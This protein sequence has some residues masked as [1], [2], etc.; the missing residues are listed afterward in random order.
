MQNNAQLNTKLP[1]DFIHKCADDLIRLGNNSDG[2]YVI[3]ACDMNNTKILVSLGVS[4]DWSFERDFLKHVNVPL[5]AYDASFNLNLFL[6][7]MVARLPVFWT[8]TS[9]QRIITFF[10]YI[11]F[12]RGDKKHFQHFV[13]I[14]AGP[15]HIYHSEVL[16]KTEEQDIF[17]KLTLKAQI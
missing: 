8:K 13:G 16:S 1:K 17:L 2:G 15:V 5:H 4:N 14:D 3:R 11:Y 6:K 12:F 7:Q 10:S 9:I